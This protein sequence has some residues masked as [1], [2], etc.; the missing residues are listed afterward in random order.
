MVGSSQ[1]CLRRWGMV[2]LL[3]GALMGC[4]ADTP[5]TDEPAPPTSADPAPLP[6]PVA[7]NPDDHPRIATLQ[8]FSAGDRACY[9][10]VVDVDGVTTE[11]FAR[12][13]L[14]DR[15]DL[16]GQVVELTYEPSSV[17]AASCNGDPD[18][19]ESETVWLI[20]AMASVSAAA[21]APSGDRPP[22]PAPSATTIP[23]RVFED[24]SL[25]VC[26]D[27]MDEEMARDQSQIYALGNN[28]YLI[29][30]MCFLAAYQGSYEY[31]LYEPA[32]E[33]IA[34][35]SFQVFY[36]DGDNW[37]SVQVQTLGGLPTYDPAQQRLE[38]FT[39]FRGPGDCGSFAQYQWQGSGFEL[40]EFRAKSACDGVALDVDDYPII[41]P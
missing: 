29:E 35:L 11:Q 13:E 4:Q 17:I 30:V 36:E 31:W 9:A 5:T 41:Y 18:C 16:L 33:A 21:P 38:I 20:T 27:V 2:L 19:A 6:D 25:G 22:S 26:A 7:F 32:S 14:C 39:K 28:Q 8:A 10:T 23:D 3:A 40:V 34:P 37:Q 1:Y 15:T 24:D 12:F